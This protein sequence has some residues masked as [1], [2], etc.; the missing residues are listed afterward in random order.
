MS[1]LCV[2]ALYPKPDEQGDESNNDHKKIK[3]VANMRHDLE[4]FLTQMAK[5]IKKVCHC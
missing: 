3:L 1:F 4:K 2:L 5:S